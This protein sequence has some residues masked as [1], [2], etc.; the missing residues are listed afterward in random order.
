MSSGHWLM[1][2]EIND[3]IYRISK[4]PKIEKMIAESLNHYSSL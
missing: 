2:E 3:S 4:L 1:D